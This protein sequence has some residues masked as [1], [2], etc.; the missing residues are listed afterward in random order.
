[1]GGQ[2]RADPAPEIRSEQLFSATPRSQGSRLSLKAY[3]TVIKRTRRLEL[4]I[5]ERLWTR[6]ETAER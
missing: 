5:F 2:R 6:V 1:M 3:W 4:I